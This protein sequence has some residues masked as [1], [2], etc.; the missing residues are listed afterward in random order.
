MFQAQKWL[1][2]FAASIFS[3]VFSPK[4]YV[5]LSLLYFVYTA[6]SYD[7]RLFSEVFFMENIYQLK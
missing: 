7:Q 5:I 1:D 2:I 3:F 4:D 6:C